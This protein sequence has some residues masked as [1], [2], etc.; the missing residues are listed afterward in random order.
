MNCMAAGY[1][2]WLGVYAR[3]VVTPAYRRVAAI[4]V[5]CAFVAAVAFGGNGIWPRD[6][7]AMA[8]AKPATI[9]LVL[10]GI[11]I[12][13]YLPVARM[14]VRAEPARY[15]LALPHGRTGPIV[16]VGAALI[17]LQLPWLM[18]WIDPRGL[19]VIAATSAILVGLSLIRAPLPSFA[20]PGWRSTVAAYGGMYRRALARRAGDAIVR[21]LGLAALAGIVG[22][23]FVR[24]N[25]MSG[26]AGAT[27]GAGV[28][29]IMLVPARVGTL[30]VLA[31]AHRS[32]SWIA[33]STGVSRSI[34]LA[35]TLL[36]VHVVSAL[37]AVGAAMLIAPNGYWLGMQ[38]AI[39]VS[40]AIFETRVV[41][42]SVDP[43]EPGSSS[44]PLEPGSSSGLAAP[45]SAPL[46]TGALAGAVLAAGSLGAFGPLGLVAALLGA[47][48][49]AA[50]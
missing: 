17:A 9:G 45:N 6:L 8:F 35:I 19:V 47:L 42:R 18:L 26:V 10:V 21:G 24:N 12:L 38:L 33:A 7:R 50:R 32:S 4:W 36:V 37:L 46:V 11:W 2:S 27:L 13:V 14:L 20:W 41:A 5:G 30:A 40:S 16:V 29:T 23:L 34:P 43:L 22:A 1:V 39:A 15:L 28:A 31:D 25:A 48:L 3:T 44:G 49:Y